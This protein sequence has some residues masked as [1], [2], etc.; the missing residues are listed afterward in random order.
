[1]K[2]G[3]TICVFIPSLGAGGAEKQS[4][5]LTKAL[6]DTH[7]TY[8]FV[9]G[10][11][12]ELSNQ[13]REEAEKQ[14]QLHLL[15]GGIISKALYFIRFARQHKVDVIL[16][17]L[18]SDTMFAAIF[19]RIAGVK[20]VFG[21]LRNAW[22]DGYKRVL[23]KIMHNHLLDYSIS[24]SYAGKSY[25]TTHGF[26]EKKI[27]VKHNGIE[28]TRDRIYREEKEV[29]NIVTVARFV[30][31]KDYHT[32]LKTIA[33]VVN[34]YPLNS[35][36]LY[37]IVGFGE[38]EAQIRAWIKDYQLEE[39]VKVHIRPKYLPEL[40]EQADIYFS[41][42]LFEGIANSMMEAMMYSLPLVATDAGDSRYL[43]ETNDNGFITELKDVESMAARLYELISSADLR[44]QMGGR[45]YERISEEFSY[46]AFQKKYLQLI[47][48][49]DSSEPI[50]NH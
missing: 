28:I 37:H 5:L 40:M 25:L 4:R 33:H 44:Q 42:S 34:A 45:S 30:P 15:T 31:Q 3:K 50:P 6:Q 1:M 26:K 29:V 27:L 23:L 22:I 38:Q 12:S 36:I 43:V 10:N 16:S 49:L 18:P 7:T 19:G 14:F 8:L 39:Y 21:G 32:A 35:S 47:D 46:E 17:H 41:S 11:Q 24:N 13:F 2:E 20:H 48:S 9:L